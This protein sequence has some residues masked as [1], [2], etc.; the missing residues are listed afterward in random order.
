MKRITL[1][2]VLEV[3][4]YATAAVV[5]HEVSTAVESEIED[6]GWKVVNGSARAAEETKETV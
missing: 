1:T 6:R 4:D 2:L 3:P 5:F